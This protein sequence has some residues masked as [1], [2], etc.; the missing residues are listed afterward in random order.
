MKRTVTIHID[1]RAVTVEIDTTVAVA[2]MKHRAGRISVHGERREALCGMGI[3]W[4]C[5][6]RVDDVEEVRTCLM[7][8][9]DGMKVETHV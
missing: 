2:L 4:E 3:C 7:Q 9:R 1:D 5:R 6:A 8:V